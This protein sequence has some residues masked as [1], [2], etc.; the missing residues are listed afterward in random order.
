[1]YILVNLLC[2]LCATFALSGI[3]LLSILLLS[4]HVDQR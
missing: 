1:M 3:A 2:S 4:S